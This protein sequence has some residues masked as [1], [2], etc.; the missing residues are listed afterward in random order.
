V[1]GIVCT[2]MRCF[3][4]LIA[5]LMM[6][7]NSEIGCTACSYSLADSQQ[8]YF[9]TSLYDHFPSR[10]GLDNENKSSFKNKALYSCWAP[11]I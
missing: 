1:K 6:S 3:V 2:Q 7:L 4:V 8:S 5:L 10:K 9:R 11:C